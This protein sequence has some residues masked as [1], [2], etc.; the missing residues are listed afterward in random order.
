MAPAWRG[1]LPV[2]AGVLLTA[3]PVGDAT[4]LLGLSL[5][6]D[7]A[8]ITLLLRQVMVKVVPRVALFR[9]D[10][11]TL[12]LVRRTAPGLRMRRPAAV[13]EAQI[14]WRQAGEARRRR[15]RGVS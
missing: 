12:T 14:R 8:A 10:A 4:L 5:A 7:A 11:G 1:A 13:I 2:A 15:L 9:G 3:L 6:V